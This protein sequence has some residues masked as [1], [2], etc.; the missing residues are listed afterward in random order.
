MKN[1][2]VVR[3]DDKCCGGEVG[4]LVLSHVAGIVELLAAHLAGEG[5]LP[6]VGSLMNQE[7]LPIPAETGI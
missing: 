1:D 4:P 7:V 2:L 6:G 3:L 5:S